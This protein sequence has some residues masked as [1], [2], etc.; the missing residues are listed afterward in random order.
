MKKDILNQW[1]NQYPLTINEKNLIDISKSINIK[2]QT[3]NNYNIQQNILFNYIPYCNLNSNN[4]K[5]TFANCQTDLINELFEKYVDDDTLVISSESEHDNVK[6]CLNNCKNKILLNYYD[7]ILKFNFFNIIN[8]I[9]NYKKIFVYFISVNI[10]SGLITP[11]V[12]FEELKNILIKNNI[13]H[14]IVLDDPHGMYFYPRNYLIFDYV[15]NTAHALLTDTFSTGICLSRKGDV[16]K[17]SSSILEHYNKLINIII[18]RK[19]KINQFK[20]ILQ[21]Y[22]YDLMLK[23]DLSYYN[24]NTVNHIIGIICK[25]S[26]WFTQKNYNKFKNEFKIKLEGKNSPFPTIRFRACSYIF[27]DQILI[28]GIEYLEKCFNIFLS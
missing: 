12:F 28:P 17:Q 10:S 23:Y 11:Q 1:L 21:E 22:F 14:I 7:D 6:K 15:L 5:I 19:S 24:Y 3:N 9:K 25:N 27:F 8:K 4:S 18:S 13:Q 2:Y 16:G 20:F 26:S